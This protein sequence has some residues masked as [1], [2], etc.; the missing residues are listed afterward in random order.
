MVV[1]G[2]LHFVA[3]DAY[4]AIMPSY[5]PLPR[6]LVQVSG[7]FEIL[8]GVGLLIPRLRPAAGIA[9]IV[10]YVAV[11]PANVNM[12]VHEIQPP[13]FRIAPVLLWARIPLQLVL[14]A[15]AWQVSRPD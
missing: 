4:V 7:G 3:T 6:E 5:L 10:L 14:M 12:A 1:A 2:A 13:G 8:G 9:L 11:L 15:W